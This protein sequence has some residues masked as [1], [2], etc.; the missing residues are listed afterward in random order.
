M[1]RSIRTNTELQFTVV[2]NGIGGKS[3]VSDNGVDHVAR[4][5]LLADGVH[6][7]DTEH[8]SSQSVFSVY[9]IAA[10]MDCHSFELYF[11]HSGCDQRTFNY[12]FTFTVSGEHGIHIVK[13]TFFYKNNLSTV[14]WY[15][16]LFCRRAQNADFPAQFFL[17]L[18]KYDARADC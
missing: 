7:I 9:L 2:R 15:C 6:I 13:V 18:R 4:S 10:C 11:Y 8:S 5:V 17:E 1:F 14:V 3:A 16:P 12:R